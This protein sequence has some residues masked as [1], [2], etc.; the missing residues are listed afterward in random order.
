MQSTLRTQVLKAV[1][2]VAMASAAVSCRTQAPASSTGTSTSTTSASERLTN[3]RLTEQS[4]IPMPVSVTATNNLFE[5]TSNTDIYVQDGSPELRNIGQYLA[6][7]LNPSTGLGIGVQTTQRAPKQ[8]NIYLALRNDAALGD[9]GYEL[10]IT[11]DGVQLVANKPAGVF[12]GI[13]TLRQS[14]PARVE[15][16]SQ[17][18]GPWQIPTGTI[19]DYPTYEY[20]G[21]MLDVARHFFGVEDVKRYIDL[22]A[23]YKMNALHLHLADDQ[24][25]RIEIKSWPRL[26]THG[27]S[28]QVGGGKGGFYTQE[29]YKDLVRY[30]Q[31]RYITIIPE[32]DMPGHTNA[33]L[34]SY[35]ELNCDNKARELYTGIEVGFSTLC[36]EKEITYKF[37]D[38]VVRELAAMTPGPFLHMGGD[39]SH[40]TPMKDYIPF[41][42]RVQDIVEKHGKR[43]IGWDE[44]TNAKLKPSTVA[45]FWAKA[46]YAKSA[47]QQGAKVIMS[48]A[49]KAYLDMQ[50]DSTTKLGLHWAAYIELDSA[51]IWDPATMV[52][53]VTKAHILGV[54]APIWT[55]TLTNMEQLEYMA[56]P[57]LPGI[58]EVAWSPSTVRDWNTYKV[59][60]GKHGARL[61]AMG[62]N[63]YPSKLVQWSEQ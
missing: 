48:P 58:A 62:I 3:E 7:L 41:I 6:N 18:A 37:I 56:F 11:R 20:R 45:Q 10:T 2:I 54:E 52:P 14:L 43:M 15:M 47:A 35:P 33:A 39:E 22:I 4:L 26:T 1:A 9:E 57:R 8:G 16:T 28:T 34:A 51:Y 44:V 38:D 13:Q 50:Y 40:V 59:R 36:T 12:R 31:E 5:L 63:Y 19:R 30:A 61:K 27:G 29:Q 46:D 24:G 55:E 53:G 60:L 49:T 32:I 23:A 21:A 17:Q 42:N 25:W